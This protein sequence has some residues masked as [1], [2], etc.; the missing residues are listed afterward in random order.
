MN[1][2]L[3]TN[4]LA[5][6]LYAKGIIGYITIDLIAFPDPIDSENHPLFWAIG[7]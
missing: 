5:E 7:K 2:D 1:L 4:T 3:I 6:K